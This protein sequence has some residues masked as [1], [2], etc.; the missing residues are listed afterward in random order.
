M[1]WLSDFLGLRKLKLPAVKSPEELDYKDDI[2]AEDAYKKQLAR[3]SGYEKTIITGNKR[4]LATS[5]QL[6]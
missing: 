4:K 3:K 2:F 1:S 6:G 5:T